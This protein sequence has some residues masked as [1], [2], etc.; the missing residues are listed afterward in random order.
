MLDVGVMVLIAIYATT[1][2]FMTLSYRCVPYEPT[3]VCDVGAYEIAIQSLESTKK[4]PIPSKAIIAMI[5]ARCVMKKT[6]KTDNGK[7][8]HRYIAMYADV[9]YEINTHFYVEEDAGV[10]DH[11]VGRI[12]K[13]ELPGEQAKICRVGF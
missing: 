9:G 13:L 10:S 7:I 1:L 3:E 4:N 2:N 12:E 11:G 8:R 6:Y 5:K